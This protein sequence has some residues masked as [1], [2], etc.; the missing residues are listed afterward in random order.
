VLNVDLIRRRILLT[1]KKTLLNSTLKALTTFSPSV[2]GNAYH[3]TIVSLTPHGAV[4]EFFAEVRGY[5]PVSEMSEAYISNATEH[6]RV[7]QTVKTWVLSVEEPEKRMRLS[8]KDQTYWSQGGQTAFENLVEGSIVQTTVSAKLVDKIILD[9]P[10]GQVTLRGVMSVDHLA[11]VPGNKCEK[12]FAKLREGAKLNEVLI[13]SK[14]LQN[15]VVTCS[16]KPAL[17]EAANEG[18]LP[19]KYED[20]YRGRK[21]TGWVK[22]LESF[23]GFIG[24]AGSVEGIV[25]KQVFF[26]LMGLTLGHV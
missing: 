15:R 12:K 20:L 6:F 10:C 7:G 5:L 26:V 13:L 11:D 23:G 17:I 2:I 1:T 18:Q 9:I 14:N 21:I 24:F 19:T 22:N 16:M 4:V 3:G 25:H 8:L